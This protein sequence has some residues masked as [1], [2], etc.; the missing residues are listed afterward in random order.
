MLVVR[1]R[2]EAVGVARNALGRPA[3]EATPADLPKA[4]AG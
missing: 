3:Y 4:T 1:A 2:G